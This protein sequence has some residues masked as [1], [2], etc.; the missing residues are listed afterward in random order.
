[1]K[2]VEGFTCDGCGCLY[3]DP[4][5]AVDCEEKH[6]K[7]MKNAKI[8][9]AY[10]GPISGGIH[11]RSSHWPIKIRIRFSEDKFDYATYTFDSC[12]PGGM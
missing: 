1:M 8:D 9:S 4:G 11:S 5:K 10:F 3:A 12:G 6:S 7:K 2:R